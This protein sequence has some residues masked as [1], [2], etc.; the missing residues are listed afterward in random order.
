MSRKSWI[1]FIAVGFIWGI[2]Y[3]LLKVTVKELS[4]ELVVC[5]RTAIGALVLI[6]VAMKQ[7]TLIHAIRNF[8]WV[9]VYAIVEMI[10]PWILITKAEQKISSGLAGLLIATVPIWSSILMSFWGDKSVWHSKRLFGLIIGFVGIGLVVG[11]ESFRGHQDF[12]A[13]GMVIIGALGYALAFPLMGR[14]IPTVDGIAINAIAM[15]ITALLYAP[16][17]VASLPAHLPSAKVLIAM[18]AL[19]LFPTALAFILFVEL[20]KEVGPARGSLVTYLNTAF[21]V[22]LGIVLLGEPITVGIIVGLPLVLIG[23]FFA[24]RKNVTQ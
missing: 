22:L 1:L 5:G 2:P 21:A 4:P 7:G 8:K 18:A 9:L 17:S 24:S 20:L 11:I 12:L 15:A 16:I 23:S 3:L 6:P 13:I 14:K 19:G 10:I